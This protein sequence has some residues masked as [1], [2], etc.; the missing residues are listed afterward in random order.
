MPT[1]KALI[2]NKEISVNYEENEK[3]KLIEAVKS[4][5]SKLESYNIQNGKISDNKLLSF[6]AIKLQAELLELEQNKLNHNIVEKNF[7]NANKKNISL[8]DKIYELT[9]KNILLKKENELINQELVSIKSQIDLI[10]TLVKN[11]YDE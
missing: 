8:N 1:Y 11:T 6:L 9:E 10:I 2:L 4:I 5:N 3:E 7:E